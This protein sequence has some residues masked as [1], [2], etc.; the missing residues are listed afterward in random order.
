M[1]VSPISSIGFTR[2]NRVVK[3]IQNNQVQKCNDCG[4]EILGVGN[5]LLTTSIVA[6][7]IALATSGIYMLNKKPNNTLSIISSKTH[8]R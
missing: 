1:K 4:V 7:V 5:A 8:F 6:S 3:P 2:K